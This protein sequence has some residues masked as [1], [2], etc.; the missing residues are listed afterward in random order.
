MKL[1]LAIIDEDGDVHTVLTNLQGYAPDLSVQGKLL[2]A[3]AIVDEIFKT[4]KDVI[5]IKGQ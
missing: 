5:E 3:A 2:R 1:E 4:V